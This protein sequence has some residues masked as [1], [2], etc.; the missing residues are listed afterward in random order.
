MAAPGRGRSADAGVEID[1]GIELALD[2]VVVGEDD[3]LQFHRQI[4]ERIIALPQGIEHLVATAAQHLG[5][6]VVALVDAA[7]P[8]SGPHR[9]AIAAAVQA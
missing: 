5:A 1:I 2:E 3:A 8:C 6:R 4:E 9:A 7:S